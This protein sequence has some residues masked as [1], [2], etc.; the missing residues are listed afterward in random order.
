VFAAI[1]HDLELGDRLTRSCHFSY[2]D[3][4]VSWSLDP[5]MVS[6]GEQVERVAVP[7]AA[8][9]ADKA[10]ATS[11]IPTAGAA[12]AEAGIEFAIPWFPFAC[13]TFRLRDDTD[14]CFHRIK[15]PC[16]AEQLLIAVNKNL[17]T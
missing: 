7:G 5:D 3:K 14:L 8:P 1:D 12:V 16:P 15:Q 13:A 9:G 6:Y 10:V 17:E 4:T 11:F 2:A